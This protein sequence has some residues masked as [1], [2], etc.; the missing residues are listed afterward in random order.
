ML[1]LHRIAPELIWPKIFRTIRTIRIH[2]GS[3]VGILNPNDGRGISPQGPLQRLISWSQRPQMPNDWNHCTKIGNLWLLLKEKCVL[4]IKKT[5]KKNT[6]TR[7][8]F[9]YLSRA[10]WNWWNIC[11]IP[12]WAKLLWH[13]QLRWGC[14]LLPD[15]GEN[16]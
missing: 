8:G 14:G 1:K 10:R 7:H 2:S 9:P 13:C 4:Y 3:S 12:P 5:V 11:R 16:P 15:Q 6:P